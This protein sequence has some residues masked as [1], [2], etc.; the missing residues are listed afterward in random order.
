[1]KN[2]LFILS[3]LIPLSA[4]AQTD[5]YQCIWHCSG[6][7]DTSGLGHKLVAAGDQNM[8]GYDDILVAN[9]G[10][11]EVFLYFGGNPMDTIP[12]MVF[13]E[14]HIY[15]FGYLPLECRDL[16]GDTYPDFTIG[17]DCERANSEVYV[18]FGGPMLD[19]QWDLMLE[20]DT[21][22]IGSGTN[23]GQYSSMGDFNGDGYDDLV[24]GAP[25]YLPIDFIEGKIFIYY[26]GP[27]FDATPDFTITGDHDLSGLHNLAFY[28][29]CYGDANNDGYNDI[30]SRGF[31]GSE[32]SDGR[33]LFLGG[34]PPD[35]LPD[36]ELRWYGLSSSFM[37]RSG[38][39]IIPD[40]TG[41]GCDEIVL[42]GILYG[43]ACS[44]FIFYGGE[45]IDT[46]YNFRCFGWGGDEGGCAYAGD[47]NNDGWPDILLGNDAGRVQVYYMYPELVGLSQKSSD[48]WIEYPGI[49]GPNIGYAGDINGDGV[50]DFMFATY[51]YYDYQ[52]DVFIYS[53]P[54]L[55]GVKEF[56]IQNPK[57]KILSTYP[58]PFNSSTTISF[59]LNS[60]ERIT[61]SVYN[62]LGQNIATLF[63]GQMNSGLH[64]IQWN[65]RGADRSPLPSG[66]YI[67]RLSTENAN[68]SQIIQLLK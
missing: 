39:F 22:H 12:D 21:N 37:L 40:F 66:T 33:M 7:T 15:N 67:V 44:A 3:L 5:D 62:L 47:V 57:F 14:E 53:D 1:M 58:N 34:S 13:T 27:D 29:S 50:D 26:G 54:D 6:A 68:Q 46:T 36:W 20:P 45:E 59:N 4:F 23:F 35:S 25:F 32:I 31:Y 61:L 30:L 60:S 38:S 49:G 9:W 8:D 63:E 48:Y 43:G 55:S 16:N 41:D 64:Q 56:K 17:S 51:S 19:N 28:I 65:G 2:I 24:I 11:G 42:G 18:Y 52:G 10:T